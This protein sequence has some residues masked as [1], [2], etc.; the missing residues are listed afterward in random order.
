[1]EKLQIE[2]IPTSEVIEYKNNPKKHPQG[3]IDKLKKSIKEFGFKNPI[4]LDKNNEI[5]AGHGRFKASKE[6]G[7]NEVP[8][9]W[10]DDLSPEQVKAFRIADNKLTEYAEWDFDAINQEIEKLK[11][12]DF[13][14][15]LTGLE[16]D[17]DMEFNPSIPSFSDKEIS[18]E[19]IEKTRDKLNTKYDNNSSYIEVIC[20]KC[21]YEFSIEKDE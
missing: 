1:M 16:F 5:I 2:Y 10:A 21:G 7:F 17:E 8:V 13:D 4:I 14:L 20:P 3:Q 19:D 9:I 6:L 18:K 15:D 12:N 11:S